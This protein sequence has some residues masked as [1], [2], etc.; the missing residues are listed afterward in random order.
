MTDHGFIDA[1]SGIVNRGCHN[2][3]CGTG[4][5]DGGMERADNFKKVLFALFGS[6]ISEPPVYDTS[7][8]E[9]SD[10]AGNQETSP[11]GSNDGS[12]GNGN[13][14]GSGPENEDGSS[15]SSSGN[16]NVQN[17]AYYPDYNPTWSLGKCINDG[18]P[19][20]GRPNYSTL[21]ECCNKAYG[22]QA[23]GACL[24]LV[25]EETSSEETDEENTSSTSSTV[26]SSTPSTTVSTTAPRD[27][28]TPYYPDYN[29]I[30]SLGKC[31][32]DGPAPSGRP[33]F[34]SHEECCNMAYGGQ[35]SGVCL[36]SSFE[37]EAPAPNDAPVSTLWYPD[38]NALWS[39]GKCT[40]AL[41][42]E[43][44]RPT[45]DTQLECCQNAYRGQASGVCLSE[46]A[47]LSSEHAATQVDS[48][49]MW[50]ADYNPLWAHGKC[51]KQSPVPDHRPWYYTQSECCE[52]VYGGQASGAC[53]EGIE[54][55][56]IESE[57]S[58]ANA[59][60]SY[61]QSQRY[62]D[63]IIYSC[64]APEIPSNATPIDIS[65]EYEYSVPKTVRADLVL[66]ELKRRMME[67][68]ADE[69]GCQSSTVPRKLRRKEVDAV[70]G[71]QASGWSDVIDTKK[72]QCRQSIDDAAFVCAPVVGHLVAFVDQDSTVEE[73]AQAKVRILNSIAG[74]QYTSES[75][76]NVVYVHQL[77]E[78]QNSTES[79]P[80]SKQW[81]PIVASLFSILAIV[82]LGVHYLVL[83]RRRLV[84][85][86][87]HTADEEEIECASCSSEKIAIDR[88]ARLSEYSSPTSERELED[89]GDPGLF[90]QSDSSTSEF[91]QCCAEESGHP[92]DSLDP[93]DLDDEKPFQM[94]SLGLEQPNQPLR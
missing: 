1:V 38:Y 44:G 2:P 34:D 85:I 57:G 41:P 90:Y 79:A 45:Y 26:D 31:I 37:D 68:V 51:I 47:N 24:G 65:Y 60:T 46:V 94:S 4:P 58:F 36:G 69:F 82:L 6:T 20:L 7:N 33:N 70:L 62:N 18:P 10:E 29:P 71:F 75:I 42:F 63:L 64:D 28:E 67:H 30:W 55:I 93:S 80:N 40:D 92:C 43:N 22:G 66:A 17:T 50:Y 19:P 77:Q 86:Q 48:L 76:K 12:N 87:E 27:N 81:V 15:S 84:K 88:T 74:G 21:E 59:F 83:R 53:L 3:P 89:E 25:S 56:P 39:Q 91:S 11:N 23:S 49:D 73:I 78:T 52:K 9:T 32:N 5:L 16:S 8:S 14:S 13:S 61:L 72:A 35:A 54:A